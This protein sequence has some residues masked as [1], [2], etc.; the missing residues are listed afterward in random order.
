MGYEQAK[1][2]ARQRLL[3]IDRQLDNINVPYFMTPKNLKYIV[4]PALYLSLLDIPGQQRSFSLAKWQAL[5]SVVLEG[6]YKNT[7]MQERIYLF[8][9]GK[10]ESTE[11]LLLLFLSGN[12]SNNLHIT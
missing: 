8:D 12:S 4:A 3:D 9:G 1:A 6:W 5:P 11:Q 2:M 10:V 7:F